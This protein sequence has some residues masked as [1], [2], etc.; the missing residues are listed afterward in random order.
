MV[1]KRGGGSC[2]FQLTAFKNQHAGA[3]IGKSAVV[4][5]EDCGEPPF[6]SEFGKQLKYLIGRFFVKIAGWFVGKEERGVIH[7]GSGDSHTLLF[8][9]GEFAGA[10]LGA[11][12]ESDF[13]EKGEGCGRVGGTATG[14]HWQHDVFKAREV[15]KQAVLLPDVAEV[16]IAEAGEIGVGEFAQ[17]ATPEADR[18]R[19]RLVE[20][21]DEVEEGALACATFAHDG[22]EFAF[23]YFEVQ[24]VE[25][26]EFGGT[27]RVDAGEIGDLEERDGGQRVSLRR[28][29]S[30]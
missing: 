22:D 11:G 27:C 18:S 23:G 26:G 19:S 21:G 10:V 3:G 9:A 6:L 15:R 1:A 13:F 14:E 30:G 24:I 7:Q 28:E 2:G 12:G 4:S 8:A 5:R 29:E 16:A 20:S 25:D 17:V